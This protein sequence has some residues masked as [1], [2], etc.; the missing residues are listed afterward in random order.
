MQKEIENHINELK[1]SDYEVILKICEMYKVEPEKFFTKTRK[2][3]V[4]N[5]RH[6]A[7]YFFYCIKRYTMTKIGQI[8]SV[9]PKDHTTI[10]NSLE[11]FKCYMQTEPQQAYNYSELIQLFKISFIS[12]RLKPNF[13]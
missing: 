7:S 10:I 4:V 1:A 5:A 6:L 8:I 9:Q 3:N 2:Q 12:S 11:K 13:I